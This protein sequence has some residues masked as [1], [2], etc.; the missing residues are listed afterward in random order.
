METRNSSFG[1]HMNA[2]A[3][4]FLNVLSCFFASILTQAFSR[5]TLLPRERRRRQ[6]RAIDGYS[7][8]GIVGSV[9]TDERAG[10]RCRVIRNG[11]RLILG[12]HA[13][14]EIDQAVLRN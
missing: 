10:V 7:S 13:N 8:I 9:M 11:C 4:P 14:V 12:H 5:L 1:G 6:H 3:P 2:S